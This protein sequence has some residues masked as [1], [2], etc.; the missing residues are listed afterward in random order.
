MYPTYTGSQVASVAEEQ[1]PTLH[2]IL[3]RLREANLP[4]F[5]LNGSKSVWFNKGILLEDDQ[6]YGVAFMA[7]DGAEFLTGFPEN[8]DFHVLVRIPKSNVSAIIYRDTP[9]DVGEWANYL[10]L[11]DR[12]EGE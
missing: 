11:L 6:N 7:E 8:A 5:D 10:T 2:N 12:P 1:P 4:D 3:F 9:M